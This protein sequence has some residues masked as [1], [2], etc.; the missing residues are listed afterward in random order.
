M[1]IYLTAKG[2]DKYPP[3]AADTEVNF[4]FSKYWNSEILR[5]KEMIWSI[6]SCND[7]NI[8]GHKSRAQCSEFKS[9]GY[10]EFE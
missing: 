5:R 2:L 1:D 7:Y 9:K 6:H 4:F 8:F 10:S 3:L